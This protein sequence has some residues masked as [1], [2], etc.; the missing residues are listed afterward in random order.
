MIWK[1]LGKGFPWSGRGCAN[2]SYLLSGA[3]RA[4]ACTPDERTSKMPRVQRCTDL[5]HWFWALL[6]MWYNTYSHVHRLPNRRI[7]LRSFMQGYFSPEHLEAR[8]GRVL[9]G[10][11]REFCC[12]RLRVFQ[13]LQAGISQGSWYV[14]PCLSHLW[15]CESGYWEKQGCSRQTTSRSC[16]GAHIC[17]MVFGISFAGKLEWPFGQ[18]WENI[19]LYIY[20]YVYVYIYVQYSSAHIHYA[21]ICCIPYMYICTSTCNLP[22]VMTGHLAERGYDFETWLISWV[23]FYAIPF[24]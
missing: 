11:R 14:L 18:W 6:Q 3:E 16:W 20:Y 9:P 10:E 12:S 22:Q 5:P 19:Y 13:D 2:G 15:E 17:Q 4:E 8:E 21:L 7:H 24:I 23:D 1:F